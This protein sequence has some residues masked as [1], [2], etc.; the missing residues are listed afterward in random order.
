MPTLYQFSLSSLQI[1]EKSVNEILVT[2]PKASLSLVAAGLPC[3]WTIMYEL[4]WDDKSSTSLV[5]TKFVTPPVFINTL[6]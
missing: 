5:K 3:H 6:R 4:E 2:Q 1:D